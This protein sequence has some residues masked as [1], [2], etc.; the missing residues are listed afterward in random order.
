MSKEGILHPGRIDGVQLVAHRSVLQDVTGILL[1]LA[2]APVEAVG[3]KQEEIL[4]QGLGIGQVSRGGIAVL[5]LLVILIHPFRPGGKAVRVC[6]GL[7]IID[8]GIIAVGNGV[9]HIEGNGPSRL[10]PY[11]LAVEQAAVGPPGDSVR[12][13]LADTVIDLSGAGVLGRILAALVIDR[14]AVVETGAEEQGGPVIELIVKYRASAMAVAEET[15]GL[16]VGGV[17]AYTV[18]EEGGTAAALLHVADHTVVEIVRPEL[19]VA[20]PAD[21]HIGVDSSHP[22]GH[23]TSA[24]AAEAASAHTASHS[25]VAETAVIGVVAVEDDA[26][27]I[28]LGEAS[29]HAGC[30]ETGRVLLGLEI[31][32]SAGSHVAEPRFQKSRLD[33]EVDDLFFLTVVDTG[34]LGLVGLLVHHLYLVDNLRGDILGGQGRVVQEELLAVNHDLVDGLAL[35]CDASV[36]VHLHSG[37]FLEEVLQHIVVSS[38][39]EGRGILHR[40]FLDHHLVADSGY[41]HL[42]QHGY[43]LVHQHLAEVSHTLFQLHVAGK[44]IIAHEVGH[45]NV[46][47]GR[48]AC[49]HAFSVSVR[50]GIISILRTS[51]LRDV[52]CGERYRFPRYRVGK[53]DFKR[54]TS[55]LLVLG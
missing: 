9:V 21:V 45:E 25:H 55:F 11:P 36:A 28:V 12:R 46:L 20:V 13:C 31:M 38:L 50:H 8:S 14:T 7:G 23:D 2:V 18:I 43:I 16:V 41:H 26:D 33:T 40:V 6:I 34:E 32:A 1:C 10:L 37:K 51:V 15:A 5:A 49:N 29:H 19:A 24:V 48:Y 22:G 39:E 42:V 54:I 35:V 17:L 52:N 47:S 53:L 27:L 44:S 4:A 3:A 30:L